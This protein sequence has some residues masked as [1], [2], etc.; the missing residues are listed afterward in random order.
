MDV[1]SNIP[2]VHFG[3]ILGRNLQNVTMLRERFGVKISVVRQMNLEDGLQVFINSGLPADRH[4]VADY[5]VEEVIPVQVDVNF[6]AGFLTKSKKIMARQRYR[7]VVIDEIDGQG[8]CVLRGR[9]D[10]CRN[11]FD[12]FKYG[13]Y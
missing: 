10:D 7:Y 6:G 1:L 12:D 8:H 3:R 5:L 13:R 9:L 4:E 2:A 11:L